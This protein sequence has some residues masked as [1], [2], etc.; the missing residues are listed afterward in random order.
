MHKFLNTEYELNP[1]N[2]SGI[3]KTTFFFVIRGAE[4]VGTGQNLG[5]LLKYEQIS[6]IKQDISS[7][8][9]P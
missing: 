9:K 5:I 1:S 8:D 3:A 2:H 6:L 4:N 7:K